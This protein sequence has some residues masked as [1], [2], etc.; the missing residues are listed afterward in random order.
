MTARTYCRLD[1]N[2]I[3]PGLLLNSDGLSFT[4]SEACDIH[5]TIL[6][7]ISASSG[8]FAYEMYFWSTSRGDLSDLIAFGVAEP[9]A[10]LEKFVGEESLSFGLK[11][12]DGEVWNDNGVLDTV[13]A[14]AERIAVGV[15]LHLSPSNCTCDFM[16]QGNVV[17]TAAI[18]TGKAWV[19]AF[20]IGST[21]AGD[22]M[23]S[24][25]FGLDRFDTLSDVQGWLEF[26]AGIPTIN[27]SLSTEA[28]LGIEEDS[29]GPQFVQHAPRLLNARTARISRSPTPW[30][31]GGNR[32]AAA[33][34]VTL[35]FDNSR[36]DF[37]E[38]LRS[39]I[40]DSETIL[41]WTLAPT[42]GAGDLTTS[43]RIFTGILD[44]VQSPNV[45]TVEVTL[46]DALSRFDRLLPCKKVPPFYDSSSVGHIMP[47]GLGAQRN[48]QPLLLDK[49]DEG[50]LYAFGDAPMTNVTLVTDQGAPLDPYFT[51]PQYRPENGGAWIILDTAPQGRL[52]V[53][54][55]S[56]GQQYV[57][58]GAADVLDGDGS[59]TS[60]TGGV[61]DGW[62]LPTAPPFPIPVPPNGS[63][64]HVS[65]PGHP[66]VLRIVSNVPYTAGTYFGFP[67]FTDELLEPG[68]SYNI[69]FN[70]LTTIGG[71]DSDPTV[72]YG[73]AVLAD[74]VDSARYWISPYKDPLVVPLGQQQTYTFTYTV[75]RDASG[76]LPIILSCISQVGG[77]PP[78]SIVCLVELTDVKVEKLGHYDQ[79]PLLGIS[80]KDAF[81]EILVNRAGEDP[82]CFSADDCDAIDSD[83]GYK[84]GFRYTDQPNILDMLWDVADQV[85]AVI[86]SDADNVIRIRRLTDPSTGTPKVRITKADVVAGSIKQWPDAG[87]SLTTLGA[88]T[89]NCE[90]FS[91]GDFVTDTVTVPA[92]IR[93]KYQGAG[94]YLLSATVDVAQ[95]YQ[96]ARSR[97]RR[98]F[99]IDDSAQA[100]I[101]LNRV[102]ELFSERAMF[103]SLDVLFDDN[104]L[105][106]DG[107]QALVHEL[108]YAD[109]ATIHL[110]DLG[111]D[112]QPASIVATSPAC[113]SGV[114]TLTIRYTPRS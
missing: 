111:L 114:I 103:M 102:N 113:G 90:P 9:T 44:S 25:N 85:G 31:H 23:A 1:R 106:G 101:E 39:D 105:V 63:I 17:Y 71:R 27:L 68:A 2:R 29:S 33:A 30:F 21:E 40:R 19:P 3:G 108:Y 43:V 28:F 37:N 96:A 47:I 41:R 53:D 66:D 82:T 11:L 56:V 58:P 50:G 98:L 4:T 72:K 74:F 91:P 36:G 46:R 79:G 110:P 48:T 15:V 67:L 18:P 62:N 10:D 57:I 49:E 107:T 112:E 55:S 14:Q 38:L 104:L 7:D 97:E 94:Q 42:R 5:R 61:P 89:P 81:T 45:S 64:A 35:T 80:V 77:T 76:D 78:T 12:I 60:W 16:V 32:G 92:D 88:S 54:C 70:L 83:T 109:V 84:L 100:Q 52:A 34:N 22:I 87:T 73:L 26:S 69:T 13:D 8:T 99:R 75:P 51:P 95:E 86:F 59:F 20:S 6:G 24:V 93:A 65:R